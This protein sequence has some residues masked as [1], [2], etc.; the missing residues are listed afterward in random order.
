MLNYMCMLLVV[1][2]DVQGF[3]E[4]LNVVLDEAEEVMISS[5]QRTP[6]GEQ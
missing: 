5:D 4:Y 6:I 3:D 2:G 1:C